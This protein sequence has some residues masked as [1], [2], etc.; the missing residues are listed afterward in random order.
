MS[1]YIINMSAPE[2][3]SNSS[4]YPHT[5]RVTVNGGSMSSHSTVPKNQCYAG[6]ASGNVSDTSLTCLVLQTASNCPVL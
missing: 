4:L 5:G 1:F 6:G 3:N 2:S